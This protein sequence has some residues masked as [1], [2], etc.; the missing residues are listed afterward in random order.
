M[1]KLY[2]P[3]GKI[4]LTHEFGDD[5]FA[6]FFII[7]GKKITFADSPVIAYDSEDRA[8]EVYDQIVNAYNRKKSFTLP[9]V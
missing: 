6:N 9:Q 3:S 8:Y 7:E 4:I 1:F 5:D 2:L